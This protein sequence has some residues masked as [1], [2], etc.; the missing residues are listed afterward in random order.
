MK[1]RLTILWASATLALALA[2]V[3][4]AAGQKTEPAIK[5]AERKPF[6]QKEIQLRA[7]ERE[8]PDSV[9]RYDDR[10][11]REPDAYYYPTVGPVFYYS[12]YYKCWCSSS[13]H[14]YITL[15]PEREYEVKYNSLG[16][17]ESITYLAGSYYNLVQFQYNANGYLLSWDGYNCLN[18]ASE[19]RHDE[20]KIFL[21]DAHENWVGSQSYNFN[22]GV[23]EEIAYGNYYARTDSKGRIVYSEQDMGPGGYMTING[24]RSR[25]CYYIWHYSDGRTPNVAAEN[26]TPVDSDN[27]GSFDLDINI[28]A[29]SIGD[30]SI[31]VT[32]PDGFTLDEGN[33]SLTLDFAGKY[34]LKITKQENNSW[35]IEIKPKPVK[36]ALLSAGESTRLLHVAYKVD[37]KLK[38]GVYD[39]SV[40][41]ILFTTKGGNLVPEPAIALPVD[42]N[43]WG[44]GNERITVPEPIVKVQNNTLYIAAT[45]NGAAQIYAVSGQLLK[46]VALTAGQTTA[47]PLPPGIYIVVAGGKTWKIIV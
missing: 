42:V 17:V 18:G 35:L 1:T 28:L 26:N 5:I 11:Y 6:R 19:W 22:D 38:K 41:S 44:V 30:G 47:T 43:R 29:D 14:F 36:S 45:T 40:N 15:W 3:P 23:W 37:E 46:T 9:V 33:T 7:Y 27:K 16:R 13:D 24:R 32:F 2:N 12:D 31:T 21:Y 20:R 39:I 34:E 25:Y 10:G 4:A 8:E